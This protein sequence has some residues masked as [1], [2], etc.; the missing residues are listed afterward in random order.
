MNETI[1]H[2][3]RITRVYPEAVEVAIEARNACASCRVKEQCG[4]GES[5]Q[6]K[7][8]I[9]TSEASFFEP[10]EIVEVATERSMGIKAVFLAYVFPFLFVFTALLLL[11]R[12][13]AEESAA[14]L[15]SLVLGAGYY[16]VL[17]LFRNK[18][19]KQIIFKVRK[20]Q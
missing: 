3:A 17:Y 15:S 18:I 13:G 11:L 9:G 14:G 1:K 20:L 12:N 2:Q 4:M 5:R 16:I 7:M 10:G 6:K 19:E 8:I